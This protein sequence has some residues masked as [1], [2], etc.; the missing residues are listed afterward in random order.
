MYMSMVILEFH[1]ER[2]E[3]R[4]KGWMTLVS[5]SPLF[6]QP[7]SQIFH[8]SLSP[9]D[10]SSEGTEEFKNS[11]LLYLVYVIMRVC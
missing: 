10:I 4:G 11:F 5:L 8:C 6:L 9:R 3:R 2:A 1:E 7:C